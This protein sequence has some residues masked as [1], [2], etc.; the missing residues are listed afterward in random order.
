MP[1]HTD[2]K[3]DS[4]M[5][6]E[7]RLLHVASRFNRLAIAGG[8][9]SGKTY[10]SNIQGLPVIHTDDWMD[11]PWGDQPHIAIREASGMELF[12]I[13]GVQVA[14]FLR[15]AAQ[16]K[17]PPPVDAV[18][19]LTKEWDELNVGQRSLTKGV[20]TVFDRWLEFEVPVPVF[21]LNEDKPVINEQG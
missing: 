10:L 1:E 17:M 12:V 6:L 21:W 5:T 14:R 19:Y 4:S 7:Q 9:K 11:K 13:E 3:I 15:K 18:I 2:V 8:P 16:L 20:R